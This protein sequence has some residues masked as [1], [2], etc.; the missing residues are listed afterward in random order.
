MR[1]KGANGVG[2]F[3]VEIEVANYADLIRAQDGN[4]P[5]DQ[6]R[7]E[8]IQGV[9]DSGATKLVLPEDLVK[10]LGLPMGDSVTVR[11]A[12]GRQAKR[13]GAEGIYVQL[14]GRH[15]T[16]RAVVEPKRKTALIGAIVLEDLDLLVDCVAQQVV[17]RD[18]RGET[19]EIE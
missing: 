18:P 2:R 15:G 6:V 11:Y 3:S 17:P 19:F 10:R 8:V 4:L 7:R 9:V 16:F 1:P 14:L 5:A 12:D 13:K